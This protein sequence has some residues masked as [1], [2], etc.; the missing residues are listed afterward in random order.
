MCINRS[1]G[2]Q[3][4]SEVNFARYNEWQQFCVIHFSMGQLCRTGL[5]QDG[6]PPRFVPTVHA[7]NY[8][9]FSDQCIGHQE[10]IKWSPQSPCFKLCDFFFVWIVQRDS[11][12]ITIQ[13]T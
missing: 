1:Q 7:G 13:N 8:N 3:D 9:H 6:A 10:P 5:M 12:P 2:T 4:D 11:L